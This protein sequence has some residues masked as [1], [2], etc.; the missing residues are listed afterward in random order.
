MKPLLYAAGA[1][2]LATLAAC[3]GQPAT[4]STP[5]AAS[6]S[7]T[8]V[9]AEEPAPAPT[10][11][12]TRWRVVGVVHDGGAPSTPP[13]TASIEFGR[14][15]SLALDDTVNVYVGRYSTHR[16]TLTMVERTGTAAGLAESAVVPVAAA[17]AEATTDPSTYTAEGD[18][19]VLR[20]GAWTLTLAPAG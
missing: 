15:G 16:G 13:R 18:R 10:L 4:E 11:A 14:H 19:L 5:S 9:S 20:A 6:A 2:C 1:V 3:G 12:G 7:S 8:V 17:M